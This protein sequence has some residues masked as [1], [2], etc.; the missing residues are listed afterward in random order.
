MAGMGVIGPGLC[1]AVKRLEGAGATWKK[2]RLALR[3]ISSI[4]GVG[5][6]TGFV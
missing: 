5:R 2:R 4:S 3:A 6:L 1:G